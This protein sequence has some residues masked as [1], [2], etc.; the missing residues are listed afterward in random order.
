MKRTGWLVAAGVLAVAT[1]CSEV[2][3]A[4]WVVGAV[5]GPLVIAAIIAW[6]YP[7]ARQQGRFGHLIV[8][9]LAVSLCADIA[10]G[11]SFIVGLAIFLLAH[12]VY[13]VAFIPKISFKAYGVSIAAYGLIAAGIASHLM[14]GASAQGLLVPVLV[15]IGCITLMAATLAAAAARQR[16][17]FVWAAIGGGLFFI[18]DAIIGITKFTQDF[19]YS[20]IAVLITYWLAQLLIASAAMHLSHR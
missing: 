20:G 2:G 10:I 3:I 5:C 7:Y 16:G 18:S 8:L 15:Y 6:V 11:R 14:A 4:P 9:G 1:L 19:A 12:I 13:L 17:Q